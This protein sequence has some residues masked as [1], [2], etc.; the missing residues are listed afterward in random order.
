MKY[1]FVFIVLLI[2]NS[3]YYYKEGA[4]YWYWFNKLVII[5]SL[6]TDLI[7]LIISLICLGVVVKQLKEENLMKIKQPKIHFLYFALFII[8]LRIN[9]VDLMPNISI[10][11]YGNSSEYGCPHIYCDNDTYNVSKTNYYSTIVEFNVFSILE[12]N[13]TNCSD[14][15]FQ[16]NVTDTCIINISA[17]GPSDSLNV[18][19]RSLL[20]D[21]SLGQ[22]YVSTI[23]SD[24]VI[25]FHS[26]SYIHHWTTD[27][28]IGIF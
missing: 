28:N 23:P 27:D 10:G 7:P 5:V 25:L 2:F 19:S 4:L 11:D 26:R 18:S 22:D 8:F 6:Y 3:V 13:I 21:Y 24:D 15:V 20:R 17:V 12:V 14:K 9:L 1:I 16:E